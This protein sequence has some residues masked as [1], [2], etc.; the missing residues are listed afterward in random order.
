M[1]SRYYYLSMNF[2]VF[3]F[4]IYFKILKFIGIG[5]FAFVTDVAILN[6]ARKEY[7]YL[8]DLGGQPVASYVE[9]FKLAH[10]DA[11]I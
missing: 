6:K 1:S 7:E 4:E 3:V 2:V 9:V 11:K 10:A 5:A 8:E